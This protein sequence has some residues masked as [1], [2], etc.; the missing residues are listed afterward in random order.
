MPGFLNEILAYSNG[1]WNRRGQRRPVDEA[2]C[3]IERDVDLESI[4]TAS[5]IGMAANPPQQPPPA[6]APAARLRR[7]GGA[8][9]LVK[10]QGARRTPHGTVQAAA[11]G[12]VHWGTVKKTAW[13]V[14]TW[15]SLV[16]MRTTRPWC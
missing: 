6:P 8:G 1:A 2:V 12:R 14:G 13:Q 3:C 7:P 9:F 15:P 16:G 5:S 11:L 10:P 4:A